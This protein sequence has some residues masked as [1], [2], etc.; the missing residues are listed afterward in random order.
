MESL[1]REMTLSKAA[2]ALP[3]PPNHTTYGL[4]RIVRLLFIPRNTNAL[5]VD[6]E[7]IKYFVAQLQRIGTIFL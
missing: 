7:F 5:N 3:A 1:A 2:P 4:G 6:V